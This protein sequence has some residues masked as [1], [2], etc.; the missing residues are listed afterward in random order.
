MSSETNVLNPPA[1]AP[2]A[3]ATAPNKKTPSEVAE[4]AYDQAQLQTVRN[5]ENIAN[6]AKVAD[7]NALLMAEGM[8]ETTPDA[9]LTACRDWR[10]LSREANEATETGEEI[11]GAGTD[12][13]TII[14]QSV[15][16]IRGKCRLKITQTPTMTQPEK[17][18]LRDR[19]FVGENIF[20][21]EPTA[22]QSIDTILQH[23]AEDS[24]PGITPEK[25]RTYQTQLA[26]FTGKPGSQTQQQ[27]KA[28]G[29]RRERDTKF[30]EIMR[31]RHEIQ[32]AAD[33][34]WPWSNRLSSGKRTLFKL[35][36]GRPF[37][38]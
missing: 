16:Y 33:G 30:T 5:S 12:A 18:A 27:S 17:Q 25:L 7:D 38:A 9:L 14:R 32:H 2:N 35:P 19:Y 28:T 36:A 11:T 6:A 37:A 34:A 29:K 22:G 15:E 26:A 4:S 8:L 3:P 24:L 10:R 1:D 20:A 31:L 21:N 23:A 13:E